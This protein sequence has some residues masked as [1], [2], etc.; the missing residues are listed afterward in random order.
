MDPIMIDFPNEFTT[1]R[2]FIRMPLP[3][4]GKAVLEAL[5]ASMNEL[6]PWMKWAQEEHSEY[7]AERGIREAHVKFL[8]RDNLRLHVFLK[9]C[10]TFIASAS[11]H[12]LDWDVRKFEVGYWIDSRYGGQGYMIEAVE[13]ICSFAFE[14]LQ[15]RRLEI[16]CDTLNTRSMLIPQRLGFELEGI[17][18]NED[19]SAD[20]SEWRD[21][22]IFAKIR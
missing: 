8:Q 1:D 5:N 11:L 4:D 22:C 21:T 14:Q 12:G 6:K 20:G 2:L 15:A 10:G 18:R 19:L 3:G 9:E 17:M 13:G 16:R 7:E